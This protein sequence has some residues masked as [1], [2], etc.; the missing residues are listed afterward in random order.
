MI[1]ELADRHYIID[2]SD[3]RFSYS[4]AFLYQGTD[5][6]DVIYGN[7]SLGDILIGGK[8]DDTLKTGGLYTTTYQDE[9]EEEDSYN[10][11]DKGPNYY[12]FDKS[13]DGNDVIYNSN[14]TDSAAIVFTGVGAHKGDTEAQTEFLASLIYEFDGDDLII[15]Y[16]N[17]EG[18]TPSQ[19]KIVNFKS[20]TDKSSIDCI[21]FFY[22]EAS[23]TLFEDCLSGVYSFYDYMYVTAKV[24][25]GVPF[26]GSDE[27]N[28][29]IIGTDGDDTI[30]PGGC[31]KIIKPI[32]GSDTIII[33]DYDYGIDS[34]SFSYSIYMG[35]DDEPDTL[36]FEGG[37][38]INNLS[39]SIDDNDL[40]IVSED[41]LCEIRLVNYFKNQDINNPKFMK[42]L[43]GGDTETT[44]QEYSLADIY[45]PDPIDN[46]DAQDTLVSGTVFNDNITASA[47]VE[48]RI[49]GG[50]GND[51]ISAYGGGDVIV[52]G[53]GND[54]IDLNNSGD[55]IVTIEE[56][57]VGFVE[58]VENYTS[59]DSIAFFTSCNSGFYQLSD[60]SCHKSSDDLVITTSDGGQ[61][62]IKNY[63]TSASQIDKIAF[64][65]EAQEQFVEF[66][67]RN[68]LITEISDVTEFIGTDSDEEV[69]LV[70]GT[71][72][73][74]QDVLHGNTYTSNATRQEYTVDA[75]A[76]GYGGN[77]KIWG[78][79][80]NDWINGGDGNDTIYG[81]VGD[82][83]SHDMLSGHDGNNLIIAGLVNGDTYYLSN[84]SAEMY[85][86]AGD[87]TIIGGN[88][89]DY[90]AA[91][92]G[93]N[94]LT[95]NGGADT[96]AL[97]G[98][99]DV[100]TD[101]TALD[102]IGMA[103]DFANMTFAR[104]EGESTSLFINYGE[105]GHLEIKN[106]FTIGQDGEYVMNYNAIRTFLLA[107][108]SGIN[109]YTLEWKQSGVNGDYSM[110]AVSTGSGEADSIS[111]VP[112]IKNWIN[113]GGG[114]DTIDLASIGNNT[115]MFWDELSI[116][117]NTVTGATSTD[118]LAFVLD[119]DV[120]SHGLGGYK[121]SELTFTKSDNDLVI[122]TPDSG[123]VTVTGFFTN[124]SKIDKI[125]AFN[126]EG[127]KTEYS[128]HEDAR[129]SISNVNDYVGT[130][131]NEE[132][133]LTNGD[134]NEVDDV[135]NGS[136]YTSN[137]DGVYYAITAYANAGDG[138]D[139]IYG[140][141][142]GRDW[143]NG[144]AG[145]DTIYQGSKYHDMISGGV[146]DDL[147]VGNSSNSHGS[148]FYGDA[149][150]DTIS[151]SHGNDF[152]WGGLGNDEI[153]L[154]NGGS[155]KVMI[156]GE[157]EN[158]VETIK[159]ATANDTLK[160]NYGTS[161]Y[162]F[163][164]LSFEKSGDDLIVN[165]T[166]DNGQV[167]LKDFFTSTSKLDNVIAL[168]D[169]GNIKDNY[170]IVNDAIINIKLFGG[171]TFNGENYN[172]NVTG[173]QGG[174][175]YNILS[176]AKTTVI[177]DAAGSDTL[178]I[179][180]S[181]SD[182]NIIFNVKKDGSFAE[183]DNKLI[184]ADDTAYNA[185]KTSGVLPTNGVIISGFSSIENIN[186]SDSQLDVSL[187]QIKGDVA[188]WLNNNGGYADVA[189]ALT[190]GNDVSALIAIFED[191]QNWR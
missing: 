14:I 91:G 9:F 136:G 43:I 166:T 157:S 179:S 82:A 164:E 3:Q 142:G 63:F 110:Y 37:Y 118:A 31:Q 125:I 160:F 147:I 100:I 13:G 186:S 140:T 21:Q 139:V 44:P 124:A 5:E 67:I 120:H 51:T 126:E 64:W 7:F 99:N 26:F 33:P 135:L 23:S 104:G 108:D 131:Y 106:Y 150:N 71:V 27:Y 24:T 88:G 15:K 143:I 148:E 191:A 177:T 83:E 134:V 95:G 19:I 123:T 176:L 68:D 2:G 129:L 155:N 62:V 38:D 144:G 58:T 165:T 22:P 41:G 127:V 61:V 81:N 30:N 159:N 90:I 103:A 60:L 132:I 87:D 158:Y 89:N 133:H 94:T 69:H 80:G 156:A 73:Q 92:A 169:L 55:N 84:G 25:E 17:G 18:E 114:N 77:D 146:D 70:K 34:M 11:Y 116:G 28:Q 175:T 154:A 56:E 161:G 85:A 145:N 189:T 101:A 6:D 96:F 10:R 183:G 178:N 75:F 45:T 190:S 48:E 105:N 46:T 152:V 119:Y 174:D 122:S 162:R 16:G 111:A 188:A 138:D 20:A 121:F 4:N 128:L 172:Y 163:S 74:E 182:I 39:A 49:I 57:N 171:S 112:G 170:S 153:D 180:A 141:N 117:N 167:V 184:L 50:N 168:D 181:K 35:T 29:I 53:R 130:D 36:W 52:G 109:K 107:G 86:N 98:G 79:S 173:S 78:T 137:A 149:G 42:I 113:P 76:L 66:S 115:V 185:W 93:S 97:D 8:G 59:T 151:V 40:F 54:V 47:D 12:V 72:N 65:D 32:K 1:Q 187:S 102:R